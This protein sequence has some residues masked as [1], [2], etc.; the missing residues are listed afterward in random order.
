MHSGKIIVH[1]S[2]RDVVGQALQGGEI[3]VQRI[4]GEPRCDPDEGIQ[5]S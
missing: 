5:G 4:C 2:A 1:G 3:F